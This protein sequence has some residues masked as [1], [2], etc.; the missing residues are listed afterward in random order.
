MRA[1]PFTLLS[2]NTRVFS[3]FYHLGS[4]NYGYCK[5]KSGGNRALLDI[6]MALKWVHRKIHTFDGDP[7]SVTLGGV[8]SGT[9]AAS[10]IA[11]ES[12]SKGNQSDCTLNV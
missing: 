8:G 6:A 9:C 2:L 3:G 1:A 11:L 7:K 10:M 5:H 12:F 4:C